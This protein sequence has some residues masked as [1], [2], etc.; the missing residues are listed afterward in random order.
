MI[1]RLAVVRRALLAL[2]VVVLAGCGGGDENVRELPPDSRVT[3]GIVDGERLI[4]EGARVEANK[5]NNAGGIGGAAT[6]QLVRGSAPELLRRGVRLL[7]LPCRDGLVEAARAV[8]ATKTLAVAP[9][10]DGVLDPRFRRVFTTGLSPHGQAEALDDHVDGRARRVLPPRTH[11]G[12]RVDRLLE[13]ARGGDAT[14]SPDAVERVHAP[15]GT[16]DGT[17]FGAAGFPDPG[18]RTDEFYERFEAVY[19]R[20]PETILAALAADSVDVLSD[21]IELAG[22]PQPGLVATE[23]R[24]GLEVGAVL[25]DIEFPGGTNRPSKVPAVVVRFSDGRLRVVS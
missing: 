11:R 22:S 19:G 3:I 6:I 13:L 25:G 12:E 18:S 14:V 9:C 16:P 20:R 2:V 8:N 15:P 23:L 1:R 17:L 5:V 4:A 10:D 7:V 21:A 24:E